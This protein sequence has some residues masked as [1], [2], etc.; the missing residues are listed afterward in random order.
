MLLLGYTL[1]YVRLVL[2]SLLFLFHMCKFVNIYCQRWR[3]PMSQG[4]LRPICN[5]EWIINNKVFIQRRGWQ[6]IFSILKQY[7]SSW[8]NTVSTAIN[9]VHCR[10][11]PQWGGTHANIHGCGSRKLM[12]PVE[13]VLSIFPL[14]RHTI[15]CNPS[16]AAPAPTILFHSETRP[17]HISRQEYFD[18]T[19]H[20]VP[21][22]VLLPP[23][24]QQIHWHLMASPY[25][26]SN[27]GNMTCALRT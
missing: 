15:T 11:G 4:N 17:T 23:L 1:F 25:P 22:E 24:E 9:S 19:A 21:W 7:H 13:P 8:Y 27:G 14:S 6:M 26:L 2:F 10:P 16:Y 12:R 20:D 3:K 5:G 18:S